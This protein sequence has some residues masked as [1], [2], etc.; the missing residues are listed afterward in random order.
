MG[1]SSGF[2]EHH[3]KLRADMLVDFAIHHGQ[4]ET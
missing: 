3:A 2:T 4:N 1:F